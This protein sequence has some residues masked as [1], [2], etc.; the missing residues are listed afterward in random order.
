MLSKPILAPHSKNDNKLGRVLGVG[1]GDKVNWG[2]Y[3][4]GI[5]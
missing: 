1:M 2:Q 3:V 4:R 5:Q